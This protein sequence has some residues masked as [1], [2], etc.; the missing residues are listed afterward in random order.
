M[1]FIVASGG[2]P[3]A[4]TREELARV[5]LPLAVGGGRHTVRDCHVK[6]AD[7]VGDDSRGYDAGERIDGRERFVVTHSA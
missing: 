2:R 3:A 5:R 1:T 7:T 6:G 4:R